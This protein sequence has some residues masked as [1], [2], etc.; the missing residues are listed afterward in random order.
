M[1]ATV[2]P[3]WR[4][5]DGYN[6]VTAAPGGLTI[7]LFS[8]L[9]CFGA[10]IPLYAGYAWDSFL[11][12][13]ELPGLAFF[14]H[15]ILS[16]H[17]VFLLIALQHL[18]LFCGQMFLLRAVSAHLLVQVLLAPLFALNSSFYTFA[19]SVGTE[20]VSLSAS[21]WLIGCSVRIFKNR[22][23][24]RADW[25]WFGVSLTV[26]VL[27]R[28]INAVQ[29]ALLPLAF[30][31]AGGAQTALAFLRRRATKFPRRAVRRLLLA[32]CLATFIA[33]LAL[34]VA[35][36]T[37]RFISRTARIHDRSSVGSIFVF[38]RL[39]FLARMEAD[40][41]TAFL[42]RLAGRTSDPVLKRMLL[43]APSGISGAREWNAAPYLQELVQIMQDSGIRE[44]WDH[45][46]DQ[47]Q[48]RIAKTFLLSFE[49]PFLTAVWNDF[50]DAGKM[51]I[52]ELTTFP[53]A[54][55]QFCLDRRTEMPQLRGL[56]TFKG[57]AAGETLASEPRKKYYRWMNLSFW[58]V[59]AGWA[60]AMALCSIFLRGSQSRTAGLSVALGCVAIALLLL[61]CLLSEVLPRFLLPSWI[62]LLAA[63]ILVLAGAAEFVL[64]RVGST[65]S[66]AQ[67][68]VSLPST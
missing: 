43:A 63:I 30:F 2:P 26:S 50:L 23:N 36:R 1:L 44:G 37:V 54:A 33:L 48:N 65:N 39:N 7:L 31:L 47:Y 28:H 51:S 61:S 24:R 4:D 21:I 11:A 15:P 67:P 25:V 38:G 8:P 55:T 45:R 66:S 3:L 46:L 52:A 57:P 6:Q 14:S 9:Y 5:I 64:K 68:R 41:R 60:A 12:H 35:S 56:T 59:L 58:S 40:E 13:A 20:A 22:T 16:D 34:A 53:F 17:G 18:A 10:R 42:A 29:A 27:L 32:G 62:M 19:H 49:R